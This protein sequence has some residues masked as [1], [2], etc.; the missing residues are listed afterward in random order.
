M[1]T[2]PRTEPSADGDRDP[3]LRTLSIEQANAL[4]ELA[5]AAF[6][7]RGVPVKSDGRDIVRGGSHVYGLTNLSREVAAAPWSAWQG[8]VDGHADAMVA[9]N[10]APRDKESVDPERWM[11]KLRPLAD[12]PQKLDYE[13]PSG[14]P[15]IVALPAIDYDSH[16]AE[17]LQLDRIREHA[18]LDEFRTRAVANL[19]A[20]PAP[21][22][23]LTRTPDEEQPDSEVAI[24]LF[25]DFY[26][27]A[28]ALVLDHVLEEFLKADPPVHGCVIGIPTRHHLLVHVV[29]G[30]GI[31]PAIPYL[32]NLATALHTEEPGPITDELYYVPWL[33]PAQQITRHDE[34]RVHVM[35]NGALQDTMAKFGIHGV[36]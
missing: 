24:L 16:V 19:R 22:E 7:A 25:D 21:A 33:G 35:V 23:I 36:D 11:M 32:V 5:E 9:A 18:G 20:L 15:G 27:A 26:G 17:I 4:R 2:S 28:R 31:L 12:L 3:Y 6:T 30:N 29:R 34:D 14:L 13:S 8:M 1:T 10:V